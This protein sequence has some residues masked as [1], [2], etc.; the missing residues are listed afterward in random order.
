MKKQL[1]AAAVATAFAVPAMAQNLT[2]TGLV[3]TM[4]QSYDSG[5][6]RLTRSND[7][8]LGTSRIVFSGT[9]D[10]GG[11]QAAYFVYDMRVNPSAG[12]QNTTVAFNRGAYVGLRGGFGAIELGTNDTTATQDIDSKVSQ[13]ANMALRSGIATGAAAAS[14][15]L[16]GD[17]PNVL[18]YKSPNING[19]S[20]E[21]GYANAN[22]SASVA[23]ANSGNVADVFVQYES[24]PLGV[25]FGKTQKDAATAAAETDFMAF[26]VKYDFGTFSVGYTGSSADTDTGANKTKTNVLSAKMPLGGGLAVHGVYANAS[27]ENTANKGSGVTLAL[28]KSLSKR[29]TVYGAYTSTEAKGGRFAMPLVTSPAAD[30]T[31][32][33][34]AL[35]VGIS[36]SF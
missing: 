3:D 6:E 23:D 36:H 20:F 10:L 8:G 27:I 22:G 1:I 33:A 2:I 24:G 31:A 17:V 14:G 16:G 28:T 21:L 7:S 4:I 18:R 30:T 26:G 11:G 32:D 35:S 13:A 29:T 19:V 12:T 25:Y 15:E 9:E 5:T 34:S